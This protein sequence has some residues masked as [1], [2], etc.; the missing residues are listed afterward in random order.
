[1][2]S[3][4][5]PLILLG[6]SVYAQVPTITPRL[7]IGCES[8][9]GPDQFGNI[10][11]VAV[12]PNGDVLVT[13]KEPPMLRRFDASGKSVWTGGQKGRGPGEFVLPIRSAFTPS[14]MVVIDMTNS[15]I[16][17]LKA[18]GELVGSMP[19]TSLA[20]TSGLN[21]RGDMILGYDDMGRG[22]RVMAR[23]AGAAE[24]R[25]VARLPGSYKNKSLALAPDGSIAVALDGEEYEI[26]RLDAQGRALTPIVRDLPR[27]RRSA[28][29][30]AEFQKRRSQG[31]AMV[32]A[33]AKKAGGSG[34][35]KP[36]PIPADQRGLKGHIAVDGLRFDDS[37]RLWVHTMQGDETKT[38]LDVFA[39]G[40]SFLGAV[41]I[42]FRITTYALSGA[43]LVAAGE[44]DDG[45]PVVKV[46]TVK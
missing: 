25:Q 12:A 26:A 24:L 18:G 3:L 44:N 39:P 10:W 42:P 13:N 15:R 9:G 41:T 31:A 14:G 30:E 17:D 16:T 4:L 46:W 33:E 29:E 36:L 43:Y 45:V 7:T 37:G 40:G 32:A 19:L 2:R 1:M 38:V 34:E 35:A 6:G 22:F 20:T 5:L 23:D 21:R 28:Q 8:C 27:P 11:D